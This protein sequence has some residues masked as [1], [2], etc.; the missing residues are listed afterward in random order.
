MYAIDQSWTQ[1][2]DAAVSTLTI[3]HIEGGNVLLAATDGTA[4]GTDAEV[5]QIHPHEN[6]LGIGVAEVWPGKTSA[7]LCA[8]T[9]SA[10]A[11]RLNVIG[12]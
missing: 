12:A 1:I 7:T 9:E 5:F 11:A 3:Q 2:T 8:K 4:P 6:Y 10:L